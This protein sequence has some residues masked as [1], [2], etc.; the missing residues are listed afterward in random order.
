MDSRE[1]RNAL[2]RYPTGI[3]VISAHG[4]DGRLV[5][6]TANSVTPV[7]ADPVRLAWSLGASSKTRIVFEQADYFSVNILASNQVNIAQQFASPI[8]DRYVDISYELAG[9]HRLPKIDGSLAWYACRLLESSVV[10]DHVMFIGEV[11]ESEV[12]DGAP[13]LYF[14]GRF[15]QIH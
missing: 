5:G 9:C 1:F 14:A 12:S 11:T 3:A 7:S 13:L 4:A 2:G 6:L 10:G 15:A 8:P